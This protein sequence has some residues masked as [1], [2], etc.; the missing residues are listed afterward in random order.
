VL[1]HVKIRQ[2]DEADAIERQREQA[3][4][5]ERVNFQH[6]AISALSEETTAQRQGQDDA[7][8]TA[9]FVREV[10]KVGRNEPCPCGSQKKY[11]HCHGEIN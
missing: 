11:K 7:D 8:K 10:A 5:K 3:R 2:E 4:A 6:Q 1:S 9:P